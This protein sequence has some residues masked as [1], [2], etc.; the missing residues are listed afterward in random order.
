MKAVHEWVYELNGEVI[1]KVVRYENNGTKQVIPYFKPD[2]SAGIPANTALPLYGEVNESFTFVVEGEKCVDALRQIGVDAVT[3]QG[4]ASRAHKSNWGALKDV[5]VV[6]L[7]PDNDEAGTRYIKDVSDILYAQNPNRDIR[8]IALDGLPPKGDIVDWIQ[9]QMTD[10]NGYSED[11]RISDMEAKFRDL[12]DC[13]MMLKRPVNLDD[14]RAYMPDHRYIFIPTRDLWPVSSVDARLD[15]PDGTD[16]KPIKPS[17]WLDANA[18]VEQMTWMPG[19][20]MMIEGKLIDSGGWIDH[21][22]CTCFNLYRPPTLVRGDADEAGLWLKHVNLV[23]PN[24][25]DH[26]IRW[27]AQRVQHPADKLNHALV[28]GGKHGIGKDTILEPVKHAV[29][30]W[31]CH[32]VSPVAMLGRF[33]GFVKSVILRVS[34]ARDLGDVDRFAFLRPHEIIDCSTTGCHK[35][36]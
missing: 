36:G 11:A 13:A 21:H 33:N 5:Q 32:E 20:P 17:R 26:I 6:L 1:G 2:G 14:F 7:L 30:P 19:A 29:G 28:L 10:W 34:E 22:G 18:P 9:A 8:V 35:S 23:Y 15:W 4:G 27:L 25:F 24:D 31:N 16:G 3:S 12:V